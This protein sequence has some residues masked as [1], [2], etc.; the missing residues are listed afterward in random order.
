MS[1]QNNQE[2]ITILLSREEVIFVLNLLQADFIPGL[3]EDPLGEMT[4]EQRQL[5][6]TWAG[7]ALRAR[8]L[9]KQYDDGKWVVHKAVLRAVGG[10]AYSQNAIFF[11]H[12]PAEAQAPVRYFGHIRGDD[13]VVHARPEDVLHQ[14]TLFSSKDQLID[15]VFGAVEYKETP[16]G[17]GHEISISN[18]DFVNVRELAGAGSVDQALELLVKNGTTDEVARPFVETLVNA[19]RISIMQTLKQNGDQRVEKR[20]FTLI[21]N[22]QHTW[23]TIAPDEGNGTPLHVKSTTQN[24]LQGLL[25]QWI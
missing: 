22:N 13:I 3:D 1:N 11:Y 23:L 2:P 8:G 19:P 14:F 12:W 15:H 18:E 9:A 4:P 24:E 5:A 7:R 17:T 21:Q 10:C 16:N 25:N 20:D 6:L